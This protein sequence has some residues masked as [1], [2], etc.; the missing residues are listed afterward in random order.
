MYFLK[1]RLSDR[2]GSVTRSIPFSYHSKY[3]PALPQ[4]HACSA[5]LSGPGGPLLP[6]Q[7]PPRVSRQ[8]SG[9]AGSAGLLRRGSCR[10]GPPWCRLRRLPVRG[11]AQ[12]AAVRGAP[13]AGAGVCGG[14][15]QCQ[16][17]GTELATRTAGFCPC[18]C[19]SSPH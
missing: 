17:P 19:S 2:V 7:R 11:G 8:R 18:P 5:L 1:P 4:H 10:Q 3:F 6:C 9:R 12:R 13:T 15:G 14:S 16:F